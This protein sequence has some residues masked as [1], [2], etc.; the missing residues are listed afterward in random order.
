M[1]L[2]WRGLSDAERELALSPSSCIGGDYQRFIAEYGERSFRARLATPGRL[3]LHY[4]DGQA[5]RVDVFVPPPGPAA[6]AARRP[7]LLVYIHGG[8][9][10]ELSRQESSFAA[11]DAVSRGAAL[12]VIDYTLAPAAS[13]AGIVTECRQALRWLVEH[14]HELGFDPDRIVVAGSS[15]GA[16]LAAMLALPS[17]GAPRVRGAV[18]VSGIFELE[19]LVGTS[20]NRALGLNAASARDLSPALLPIDGF[21][22]SVVCW[23]SIETDEFKRQGRE[24][25]ARLTAAGSSCKSFEVPGRNHFDVI[26]DLAAPGTALGDATHQL[27][28]A[29]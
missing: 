23:G 16:H 24:F 22:P 13:V 14:A 10:Q 8:Y 20:I 19:P 18:L 26:L 4:G 3:N 7:P 12:A 9:W 29:A 1:P 25:A 2:G 27:L 21:A 15:A 5:H 6:A 11:T 28:R 17:S